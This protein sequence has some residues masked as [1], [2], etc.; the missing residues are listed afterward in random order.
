MLVGRPHMEGDGQGFLDGR[1]RD[2]GVSGTSSWPLEFLLVME[3]RLGRILYACRVV[4]GNEDRMSSQSRCWKVGFEG[5]DTCSPQVG[6]CLPRR[7]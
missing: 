6:L 3:R 4:D 7:V 1:W 5:V 2:S